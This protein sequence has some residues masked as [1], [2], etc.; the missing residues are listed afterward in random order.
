MTDDQPTW[1]TLPPTGR[2]GLGRLPLLLLGLGFVALLGLGGTV[3]WLVGE[4]RGYATGVAQALEVRVAADRVF[5]MLQSAETSQ[6]GYLITANPSYLELY[7]SAAAGLPAGVQDLTERIAADGGEPVPELQPTVEQRMQ[8]MAR[9]LAMAD[10]G[11]HEEAAAVVRAGHGAQLMQEL[12]ALI[13]GIRSRSAERLAA[14]AAGLD[15]AGR[16]LLAGAA[17][18]CALILL[19]AAGCVLLARRTI[20]RLHAAAAEVRAANEGLEQ[21]VAERTAD[22]A[23]ANE[24]VQRFAYIVSHDLRSPLVNVMGFTAELEASIAPVAAQLAAA[25]AANPALVSPEAR[26]ALDAE[27]PEALGFIRGATERMD[28]LISAILRLSREGRRTLTPEPVDMTVLIEGLA[29]TL[30]HQLAEAGGEIAVAAPLPGLLTDRLA[31]EQVFGNLLDNA[32]KYLDPA[33]PGRIAVRGRV[34]GSR[35][36]F[37]VEDNGRGIDGRDQE[38][39]FELFRRAG[40]QDRA[41]EGIGLAHVRALVRRLGGAVDCR[42]TPGHGSVF[43]VILPRRLDGAAPLAREAA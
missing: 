5:T 13:S 2:A 7:R 1:P 4:T 43:R 41:G 21:R 28:R 25:E 36:V 19:I 9:V 33:R 34:Q 16:V 32:V 26:R 35:A 29:A 23:A 20:A 14:R 12:R 24:E 38:R 3:L 30:R 15:K 10:A 39:I 11:Q 27:I 18:A 22:L 40:A 37:E 17:A 8:E 31:V 42:S 6:R